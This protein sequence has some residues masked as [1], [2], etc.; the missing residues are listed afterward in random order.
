MVLHAMW[1]HQTCKQQ[2][3][4]TLTQIKH[5]VRES[6][7]FKMFFPFWI[8]T[9]V[10]PGNY[11]QMIG[12]MTNTT[13]HHI[14]R[15]TYRKINGDA[16]TLMTRG[17]CSIA[18]IMAF[19]RMNHTH[20]APL[21]QAKV[22]PCWNHSLWHCS[23]A[24][25]KKPPVPISHAAQRLGWPDAEE[26]PKNHFASVSCMAHVKQAIHPKFAFAMPNLVA[27]TQ[28]TMIEAHLGADINKLQTPMKVFICGEFA[29]QMK[30]L[31]CL[32]IFPL[33][34]EK[35]LPPEPGKCKCG[36]LLCCTKHAHPLKWAAPQRPMKTHSLE[37]HPPW[38]NQSWLGDCTTGVA[39]WERKRLREIVRYDTVHGRFKHDVKIGEKDELIVNGNKIKCIQAS[40]EGPKA[41]PWKDGEVYKIQ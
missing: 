16:K 1:T 22:V 21:C 3:R 27:K 19:E 11:Q 41:L 15:K 13:M 6:W 36:I 34:L 9:G 28:T 18:Y 2:N 30:S 24:N 25:K 20:S 14:A 31:T 37:I 38:V 40:R 5:R 4:R 8:R 32:A 7:R 17:G 39:V 26:T 10:M 29:H 33:P 12:S 35:G 23:H